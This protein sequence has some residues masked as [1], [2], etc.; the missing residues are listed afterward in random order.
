VTGPI[1]VKADGLAVGKGVVVAP[2]R[3]LAMDAVDEVLGIA[4]DTMP[5]ASTRILIEEFLQGDEVSLLALTDGENLVPL[6]PAQ[7]HKRIGEGDTGSNTGG[8]GCYSP[9][10]SF[11][12]EC[13]KPRSKPILKPTLAA[14]RSEGIE[15]RGRPLCRI[16][17]DAKRPQSHRVQLPLRRPG[18]PSRIAATRKRL[19]AAVAACA[20]VPEYSLPRAALPVDGR[21]QRLRGVGV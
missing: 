19:V 17:A 1:V 9:V 10:P 4:R 16:D 13:T 21:R 6:V 14:L 18:N 3:D 15:Y 12:P 8:M 11:T 20:G 2:S 5:D 7:D